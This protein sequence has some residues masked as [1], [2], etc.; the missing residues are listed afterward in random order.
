MPSHPNRVKLH[1]DRLVRTEPHFTHSTLGSSISFFGIFFSQQEH[2]PIQVDCVHPSSP[3]ASRVQPRD[4]LLAEHA[5]A[6]PHEVAGYHLHGGLDARGSYVPPRTLHRWPAVRAW[7]EALARRGFPLLEATTRLLESG[8]YPTLAQQKLLLRHGLGQTLW[9]ALT[10][11]GVIE[12]R[13]RL[14]IDLPAPDLQQV[15]V[16]D[17][18]STAI[19]HLQKGLLTAHGMDEGGD[20]RSR[21]GAHDAMWFAIRD[22]LFG[23]D[24][25]R[26]PRSRRAS[27]GRRAAASHPSCRCRTSSWC[28]S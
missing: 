16:E 28:R 7:Q 3:A 26:C 12:A 11:T 17:V 20:P 9:N 5:Y 19:G 25:Y 13:G 22:L 4:E 15:L 2:G 23:R 6:R 10:I 21:L 24:A 18:S 14:L 1:F 27:R 8:P